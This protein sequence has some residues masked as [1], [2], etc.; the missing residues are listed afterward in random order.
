MA[1]PTEAHVAELM[2]RVRA[3][4]GGVIS[5]PQQHP[6]GYSGVCSDLDGHLWQVIVQPPQDS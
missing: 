4:G 5:E 6:W 1:V 2:D 3:G